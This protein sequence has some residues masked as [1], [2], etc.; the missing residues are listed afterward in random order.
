MSQ[1]VLEKHRDLRAAIDP[2]RAIVYG[3]R[4]WNEAFCEVYDELERWQD[5]IYHNYGVLE[6][7]KEFTKGWGPPHATPKN[8]VQFLAWLVRRAHTL[9][10]PD[11][12]GN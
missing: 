11:S 12:S 6:E 8:V 1:S 7:W 2:E 4:V 10:P 9:V 3:G 5:V